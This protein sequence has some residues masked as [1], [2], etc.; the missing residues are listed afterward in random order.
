MA[1]LVAMRRDS[2]KTLV[3]GIPY[4]LRNP[5]FRESAQKTLQKIL[6]RC[7]EDLAR[8]QKLVREIRP[9]DDAGESD[10]GIWGKD[11]PTKDPA[12]WHYG[13]GDTPG[14]IK[15]NENMRPDELPGVLA[16]E[17]GHAATRDEDLKRRGPVSGQWKSEFSADWYA[18]KWGFGRQIARQRKIR[19]T[20]HHG[21]R[22]GSTFEESSDGK[23]YHFRVTRN[24][25][26]HLTKITEGS[27]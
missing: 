27:L 24:F 3:H 16:H 17:L 7:P 20:L 10:M 9:Y 12:T 21:P 15:I 18:Y 23:V 25:V 1:K 8:L 11:V 2:K 26:G 19:V 14:I 13:N 6:E 22:P 4:F 5:I